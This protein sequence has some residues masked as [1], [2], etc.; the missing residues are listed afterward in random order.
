MK[1][2]LLFLHLVI[3]KNPSYTGFIAKAYFEVGAYKEAIEYCALKLKVRLN[4][5]ILLYYQAKSLL[6]LKANKYAL[7]LA[8]Y[9]CELSPE[10]TSAWTLL[11]KAYIAVGNY[12]YVFYM[13]ELG[14]ISNR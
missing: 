2:V 13:I 1:L 10:S 5:P 7:I 11:A 8:K 14:L 9:T 3:H 12:R 6:E 4:D